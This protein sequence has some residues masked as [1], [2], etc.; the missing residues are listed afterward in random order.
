MVL[1]SEHLPLQVPI[2][3]VPPDKLRGWLEKQRLRG[4]RLVGLEQTAESVSLS[5]FTFAP[6]TVLLLGT[7]KTGI[8]LEILQ[9]L[10]ATVEIP[11]LG[12]IRS[13]NAHVSGAIALY[14]YT[15]QM[16]RMKA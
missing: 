15:Q 16:A 4:R 9:M 11:Q 13:L 3:E 8:P 1:N 10:D 14:E 12:I 7:E 5:D 6:G 2:L